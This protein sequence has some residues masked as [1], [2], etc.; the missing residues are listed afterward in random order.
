MD[1][2]KCFLHGF[3]SYVGDNHNQE[4]FFR[5]GGVGRKTKIE[6]ETVSVEENLDLGKNRKGNVG[7]SK[8]GHCRKDRE[9]KNGDFRSG[10]KE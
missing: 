1:G 10:V 2:C 4:F 7:L 9:A 6:T 8:F 3:C 5:S